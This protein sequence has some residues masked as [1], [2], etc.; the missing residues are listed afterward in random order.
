MIFYDLILQL[1]YFSIIFSF[2]NHSHNFHAVTYK[3]IL[4]I[5][6]I[7]FI[8]KVFSNL[9]KVMFFDVNFE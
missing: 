7:Y 3:I 2:Y 1:Y 4:I 5:L 9:F 8:I 6:H